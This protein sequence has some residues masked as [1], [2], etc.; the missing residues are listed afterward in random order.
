MYARVS[1]CG[2]SRRRAVR[3]RVRV[4]V[5][6]NLHPTSAR[7]LTGGAVVAPGC[8]IY[9]NKLALI[10]AAQREQAGVGELAHT[11]SAVLHDDRALFT[12]VR[13]WSATVD[14]YL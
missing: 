13:V 3:A 4:Q 11:S 6:K 9:R 14:L 2:G 10:S 12:P 7:A 5:R 1:V 8:K